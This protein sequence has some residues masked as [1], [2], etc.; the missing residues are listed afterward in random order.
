MKKTKW[1]SWSIAA[2]F[3]LTIVFSVAQAST[4][5]AASIS[6]IEGHWAE[7][8]IQ[9]MADQ[10]VVTGFS[11]GSFKPDKGISRG[12]FAALLVKAFKLDNK[13]GKIFNDT[14]NHWAKDYI[15][16]ANAYGIVD[17]YSDTKYGPDDSIT[18]EQ[19]AVMIVKT[20]NLQSSG[21]DVSFSDKSNISSWAQAAVAAASANQIIIGF[22]DGSFHPQG[23]ATRAQAVV[24]LTKT[25]AITPAVIPADQSKTYDKAG[26][27]GPADGVATFAGN[28]TIK[29]GDIT[30]QNTIIRGDLIIDKAVAEGTVTLKGV[31]VKGDT[32]INGGGSH[33]VYFID[34]QTGK[35][36]VMKDGGP[37][38]IVIS[39]TTEI[40]QLIAQS[41]TNIQQSDLTGKGIYGIVADRQANGTITVNVAGVNIES[42]EVDSANVIIVT[43]TN[44]NIGTLVANATV[45][46]T[47]NGTIKNAAINAS[48]VEF[49]KAPIK[50]TVAAGVTVPAV[51]SNSTGSSGSGSS[52]VYLSAMESIIGTAQAG[53]PL[54]AG[55]LTPAG[56]TAAYQWL[57]CDTETGQYQAIA[58][59]TSSTY[60]P[61]EFDQGMFIKVAATG[62]GIYAGTVTSAAT[63]AVAAADTTAADNAAIAAAKEA[64]ETGPL[65]MSLIEATDFNVVIRAQAIVDELPEAAGVIVTVSDICDNPSIG[66][67]GGI[68]YTETPVT[69]NVVF[70]LN[71]GMGT[72]AMAT[73]SLT[74]EGLLM[75][76]TP[77]RYPNSS[78]TDFYS[79][80]RGGN[81]LVSVGDTGAILVSSNGVKWTMR[82]TGSSVFLRDVIWTG[83]QY[84]VVGDNGTIRTSPEGITWKENKS[85]TTQ[86]LNA[87]IWSGS[88]LVTVGDNGTILSVQPKNSGFGEA[89]RNKS[90]GITS[91][92]Y[93]I[94]WNGSQ[95]VTVGD[96]G[97][98]LTSP[99][100]VVWT[101]RTSGTTNPLKT[102]GWSGSQFVAAGY[103]GTILTSENGIDWIQGTSGTRDVITAVCWGGNQFVAVGHGNEHMRGIILTS[104]DGVAWTKRESGAS[105]EEFFCGVTW[106]G[107][108]FVAVGQGMIV[109]SADGVNWVEQTGDNIPREER[110]W[111]PPLTAVSCGGSQ[112][113]IVGSRL[114]SKDE[115]QSIYHGFI[116]NS[117]DLKLSF[118]RK[119]DKGDKIYS[120]LYDVTW[121]GNKFVTVGNSG[122]ILTSPDGLVWTRQSYYKDRYGN[123]EADPQRDLK[124][125]IWGRDQYVAVGDNGAIRTSS[126]GKVWI[127]QISG[128]D[129]G[130]KG[131]IWSGSQFVVVGD[132]GDILTSPDGTSWTV[133]NSGTTDH[134]EAVSWNGSLFVAVGGHY[135][136]KGIILSSPDGETWTQQSPDTTKWLKAITW[137]GSQFVAAGL[138]PYIYTSPD[139]VNWTMGKKIAMGS[140]SDIIWQGDQFVAVGW[141]A[142]IR[143]SLDG[144][145]WIWIQMR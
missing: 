9:K 136:D 66:P 123:H 32:H 119:D 68:T 51:N 45:T 103:N 25:L 8:T 3:I 11:D 4:T 59:A 122:A 36:Y 84:V 130:L 121:G 109:T 64:L 7:A 29:A 78:S 133:R 31:T 37:V 10:G 135:S 131:V 49:A 53:V 27:Y 48:G 132:N 38:R 126:D 127:K 44:T 102:I 86:S 2:I 65:P 110:F 106:S 33:S 5:Y 104:S 47:G 43:D 81:Q 71:K 52:L 94:C 107:S 134:L 14:S 34:S 143:T 116:R 120:L 69:G 113:V 138:S 58:G 95:F 80:V 18:R 144:V 118:D 88:Q 117:A 85:F 24:V 12:E 50:Q 40:N 100:G 108:Q 96:S 93:D 57:I 89:W 17:G 72:Q 67:D 128:T 112:F 101:Q 98:I 92:L 125:V 54:T 26:T 76:G 56:A 16:T 142:N 6:D 115:Y 145:N 70:A 87:I 83:N 21:A 90:S 129:E 1:R 61:D 97:A 139:G 99:D 79:I 82:Y 124:A 39:G 62:T 75:G 35:T 30:L 114:Y 42:L 60:N 105:R 23:Q 63:T 77:Q 22:S 73:L 111:I 28:I 91:N 46:V 140:I 137:N 13:S 141:S 41:S 15:A 55:A 74:Q 19:M 20:A